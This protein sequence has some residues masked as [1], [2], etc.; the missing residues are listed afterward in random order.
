MEAKCPVSMSPAGVGPLLLINSK[1]GPGS[2]VSEPGTGF[3]AY[4]F[5]GSGAR[6]PA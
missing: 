2:T 6:D 1:V 4:Y 3:G 5:G